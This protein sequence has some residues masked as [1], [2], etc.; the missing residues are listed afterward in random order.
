MV[1]PGFPSYASSA[2]FSAASTY[3]LCLGLD[4]VRV[5]TLS[6]VLGAYV[7]VPIPERTSDSSLD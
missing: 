5:F 1:D 3:L 2:S 6:T 4:N 7:L